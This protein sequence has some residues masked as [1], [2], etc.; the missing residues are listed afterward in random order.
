MVNIPT[1]KVVNPAGGYMIINESDFDPD[2]HEYFDKAD[3]PEEPDDEMGSLG[4]TDEE[5]RDMLKDEMED[6]A[7]EYGIE[8]MGTGKD[9]NVLASDLQSALLEAN[10][11]RGDEE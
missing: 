6:L 8:V 9:G 5:I 11:Y 4:V 10:N 7:E 2:V 3:A 1:V